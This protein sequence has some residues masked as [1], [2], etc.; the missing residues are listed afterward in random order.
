MK[1]SERPARRRRACFI[2]GA[3]SRLQLGPEIP[4]VLQLPRHQPAPDTRG[5]NPRATR[6]ASVSGAA[7][8]RSR[9]A[10]VTASSANGRGGSAHEPLPR[11]PSQHAAMTVGT[12]HPI[13]A[14]ERHDMQAGTAEIARLRG[15]VRRAPGSVRPARLHPGPEPPACSNRVRGAARTNPSGTPPHDMPGRVARLRRSPAGLGVIS[16]EPSPRP[17]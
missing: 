15:P 4:R 12:N 17:P 10:T 8:P 5:P 7:T 9:A 14:R 2:A 11:Q 6:A 3:S 1:R 16:R 13:A